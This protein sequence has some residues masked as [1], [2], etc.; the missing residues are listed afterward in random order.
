MSD[1]QFM[2]LALEEAL[3]AKAE[4]QMPVGSVIVRDQ[5]V[6]AQG[7]NRVL[8]L[9]DVT[10]HAEVM[11]IRA[12]SIALGITD[13]SGCTVYTTMEPCPMCLGAVL[14][15]NIRRLVLG[16]R[17]L[18][19]LR[20]YGDYSVEG[21]VALAG[22]SRHLTV[23]TGVLPERGEHLL[24]EWA[25]TQTARIPRGAAASRESI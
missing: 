18:E 8:A 7:H 1:T 12:A 14:A 11:A 10:A 17:I 25:L 6:I 2:E 16:G 23:A 20:S 3:R 19:E 13:L 21:L 4:G 22:W 15:S 5:V 9:A 24:R